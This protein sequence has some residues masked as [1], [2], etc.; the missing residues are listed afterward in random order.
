MMRAGA[1]WRLALPGSLRWRLVL[2][3]AVILA[4]ALALFATQL[5]WM[6]R[7]HVERSAMR[8]LS[9][10]LD[11]L[12]VALRHRPD[13]RHELR[14]PASDPRFGQPYGGLYWQVNAEDGTV[15]ARSRSLWDEALKLPLH[16]LRNGLERLRLKGPQ[17]EALLAAARAV[18]LDAG[19]GEQRYVFTVAL[20]EREIDEAVDNFRQDLVF[21]L[22]LLAGVL[23]LALAM[24]VLFGLRPL[25]ALRRQIAEIREGRRRRLEGQPVSEIEALVEEFNALLRAQQRDM[26]RARA[27]AGNLAHG[28]K[29]P[30]A[31]LAAE[32]RQLKEAGQEGA[33]RRILRQV[34][35]LREHVDHELGRTRIGGGRGLRQS[36]EVAPLLR[37]VAQ[38]LSTIRAER[39]LEWVVEVPEGLRAEMERGDFLELAGNLMDNAAKWARTRVRVRAARAS[40]HGFLL[41]V[42]DDGPGVPASRRDHILR[43]GVRLDERV[44]GSGIGLSIVREVVETYGGDIT[45]GDAELGGLRVEVRLPASGAVN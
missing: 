40:G 10:H 42:E 17:G 8:Q 1:R 43:R 38:T 44:P 2:L 41:E 6:F 30:L 20:D 11:Y 21:S 15:L 4:L 28:L 22:V 29:T 18:W 24:Q 5:S 14:A 9:H 13:G 34:R 33:A 37:Q 31:I 26:E 35:A 16:A 27:R 32:A 45:L 19:G 25:A 12:I 3:A 7:Q 39:S 23:L 36:V